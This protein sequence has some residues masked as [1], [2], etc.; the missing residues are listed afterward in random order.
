M[1]NVLIHVL[2][3]QTNQNIV[4]KTGFRFANFFKVYPVKNPSNLEIVCALVQSQLPHVMTLF[5]ILE[6]AAEQRD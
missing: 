6:L 3:N 5:F 4:Q 2:Q 1:H